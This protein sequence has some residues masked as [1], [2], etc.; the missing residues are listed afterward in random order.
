MKNRH[1]RIL[2]SLFALVLLGC[3]G[4]KEGKKEK[5]EIAVEKETPV[6]PEHSSKNAVDWEGTYK[7]T[8]PC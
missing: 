8:L 6:D 3:N 2:G 1:A 5:M 7:G 4:T